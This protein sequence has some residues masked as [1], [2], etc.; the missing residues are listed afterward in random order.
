M[1]MKIVISEPKTKK[2]YQVE[3]DAPGL[4]GVKI[5]DKFDGGIVGLSGFTL[6]LTGGSDKAGFPMRADLDGTARRKALLTKGVGFKGT[7]KIKKKTFKVKG[8]RRRKYIRGNKISD[9][10]AQVNCKVVE[11]EGDIA[12]MLGLKKEEPAA[13][14]EAPATEEKATETPKEEPKAEEKP[15]EQPK[16]EAKPEETKPEEP[17]E[18]KKE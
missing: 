4:I 5:G 7:K 3:K 2:A 14:G 11:G 15:V 10:I 12:M 6:E 18:E 8:L 9:E 16:E 17:T 13:E 1:A